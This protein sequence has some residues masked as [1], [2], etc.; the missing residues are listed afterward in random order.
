MYTDK[1]LMQ[2]E[3]PARYIGNEINMVRKN[4]ALVDIRFVFAFADVYEVGMSHNGLQILY[5]CLNQR[6]DT[7]CERVFAPWHDME[8]LM[9]ENKMPLK[10]LETYSELTNFDFI[11]F[12]LQYELTYTNILN[13][14]D[15]AN[16]PFMA[17]DRDENY[18]IICAGGPCAVNPE[19]LA[20]FFDFFF[21]GEAEEAFDYVLDLF[22]EN[23]AK[24]GTKRDFLDK[25]AKLP[26]IYVPSFYDVKYNSNGTICSFEPN[27]LSAPKVVKKVHVKDIE[28]VYY[29][30]APL[31]PLI[32]I[33]HNRA[34]LEVFRGCI[35]GCRFCQAGYIYR[36]RRVKSAEA[37]F[38]QAKQIM[39]STGHEE[40]SLLSLATNDYPFLEQLTDLLGACFAGE[41]ISLSLP[42]LRID[43]TNSS[44]LQKV[45][46]VRKSGL[47]FA[48]E[49]GSQ[50]MR[51]VINKN[52]SE[53][54]IFHGAK[55]AFEGGWDRLK[56]YFVIGLPTEEEKDLEAIAKLAS[57][58]VEIYYE[59]PKEKRRR[60]VSL[61][62]S[63]SCFIPKPFTPF[64]WFRQHTID[65]F[66][67]KQKLIKR[68][69]KNK[70][71]D[72]KYHSAETSVLEGAIS[73]ADRR[74]SAV[75]KR[76]WELGARFDGWS[77]FFRWDIWLKAFEQTNLSLE[78]YT[79]R[80]RE[81]DEILPWDFIDIGVSKDVLIRE[82][83]KAQN[84][85]VT[86]I[87]L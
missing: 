64:Q 10:S 60:P 42:S 59:M 41:N 4:P 70:R 84:A 44:I 53:S 38:E 18:P 5:G 30:N 73:R 67:E 17:T 48:P 71:I 61:N 69:I 79:F 7:Y 55:L 13:M 39:D 82:N 80:E 14:L 16:I 76:A 15:L 6:Q 32:E 81:Y 26:G 20:D 1:I 85:E 27:N 36:P 2:V 83:K 19:P 66:L 3:K 29:P 50:R 51:D 45:Q 40:I 49:G 34:A 54:E 12:T 47:T 74:M 33:V 86:E 35:R 8:A 25:L 28:N 57:D 87:K 21:I 78:F 62:V 23:K 75:I 31:V 72:Y 9:R 56:L 65:D 58:I 46:S 63:A 77:E 43:A 68:A 52:I 11:G 22:K 24:K 37:L